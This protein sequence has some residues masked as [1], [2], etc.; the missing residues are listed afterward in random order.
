M[1]A[2][3]KPIVFRSTFAVVLTIVVCLICVAGAV[4]AVIN[5]AGIAP[6][7]LLCTLGWL[8]WLGY[9]RPRVV[10]DAAGVT[11]HNPVTEVRIPFDAIDDV[12]TRYTLRVTAQGRTWSA[13]GAP[14]PSGAGTL[15]DSMRRGSR[16]D[17]WRDAPHSIRRSGSARPGDATDTPS[18]AP[19]TVI[20]R[21]LD[22]RMHNQI[23]RDAAA[24]TQ[25]RYRVPLIVI[26]GALLLGSTLSILL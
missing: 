17:S 3:Q 7:L 1:S 12:D 18:G 13:W 15:R 20:R 10:V 23:A 11:L 14:A 9:G 21:E 24:R 8:V 2:L 19:A 26:S 25:H 6:V 5:R 16:T 4:T 22:R